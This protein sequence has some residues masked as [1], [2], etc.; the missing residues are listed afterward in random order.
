AGAGGG[1]GGSRPG[2]QGSPAGGGLPGGAG[3]PSLAGPLPFTPEAGPELPGGQGERVQAPG[4]G[5]ATGEVVTVPDSPLAPG[6][7]RPYE[8]VYATYAA[9]ARQSLSGR[10]LPPELQALVQRYFSGLAP[11]EPAP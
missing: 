8:E 4:R 7:V 6:A 1:P 2:P 5:R 3:A 11:A 10:S 9:Q